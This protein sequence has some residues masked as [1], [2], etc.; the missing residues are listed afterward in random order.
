MLRSR[1]CRWSLIALTLA[2]KSSGGAG[3]DGAAGTGGGAASSRAAPTDKPSQPSPPG[4]KDE[5]LRW[6]NE[7][8]RAKKLSVCRAGQLRYPGEAPGYFAQL[9][10]ANDRHKLGGIW[11]FAQEKARWLHDAPP[12]PGSTIMNVSTCAEPA[13]WETLESVTVSYRAPE[14]NYMWDNEEVTFVE[15]EP[16]TLYEEHHDVDGSSDTNW[17]KGTENT[18]QKDAAESEA[19]GET[20]TGLL[21]AM[22]PGSRWIKSWKT[23][24]FVPF[25]AKKRKDAADANL[26]AYALDMGK[27]GIRIVADVTD[28]RVVPT[29]A[30]SDARR[31]VRSD[32][33]EIWWKPADSSINKQLG[34]GMR[35][36]GTADVR[37]LL[38]KDSTEKPPP[39]RR[40][41]SHFEID[42]SIATLGLEG[43]AYFANGQ[44]TL[45]LTVAFSDADDPAGGQETVVATSP[46]RWDKSETFGE[47]HSF[48]S[49]SKRF[50]AFGAR[51]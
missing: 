27:N 40:T 31:F 37:W 50:P 23:P 41:G 26:A 17:L 3:S 18:V 51:M 33:V 12:P 13:P 22:R 25:G 38:P 28:E 29:P 39:V 20:N 48:P 14:V 2:C 32:H 44:S 15:G 11:I 46:V 49:K 7:L 19:T 47:L 9:G 24:T 43:D 6:A 45:R 16:V 34:I 42:L 30:P 8:A 21:I 36:D 35:A 4:Q 10:H 1:A 5:F